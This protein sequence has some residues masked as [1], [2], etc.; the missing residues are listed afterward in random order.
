MQLYERGASEECVAGYVRRWLIWVKS[1]VDIDL[2][3]VV[4]GFCGGVVDGVYEGFVLGFCRWV[5]FLFCWVF[6]LI[7]R[8]VKIII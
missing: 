3:E 4:L 6:F 5:L 8:V 2:R 7:Y 1:G